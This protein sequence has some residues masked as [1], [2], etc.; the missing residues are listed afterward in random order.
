MHLK[1]NDLDKTARTGSKITGTTTGT[2]A[3]C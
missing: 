3:L 2:K 1:Q